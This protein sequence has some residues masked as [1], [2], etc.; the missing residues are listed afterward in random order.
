MPVGT[1][2]PVDRWEEAQRRVEDGES[3]P[4]VAAHVG[5]RYTTLRSRAQKEKWLTPARRRKNSAKATPSTRRAT[6]GEAPTS[7]LVAREISELTAPDRERLIQALREGPNAFRQ[8]LQGAARSTLA[9]SFGSIPMPRTIAEYKA[10]VDILEKTEKMGQASAPAR[11][12]RHA[13]GLRRVP[14]E[15]EVIEPA[16]VDGF[17]I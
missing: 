4:D 14:I 16:Q 12:I 11:F 17:A 8:A 2:I 5:I 15:A 10:V 9:A 13:S 1:C 7:T 3:M 6:S